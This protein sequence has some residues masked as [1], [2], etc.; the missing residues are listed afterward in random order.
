[1]DVD[2]VLSELSTRQLAE[3]QAYYQ[4]EPFGG[5]WHRT[6]LLAS[7]VANANRDAEKKP[8]PFKVDD[9]LPVR[10]EMTTDE[11]EKRTTDETEIETDDAPWMAWKASMQN[12]SRR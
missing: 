9:F 2:G 6:A 1:L 3:W 12:F 5:E 8:E 7:L 11:T 4:L 10:T